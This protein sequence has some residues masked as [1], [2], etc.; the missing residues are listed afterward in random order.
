MWPLT[1][2]DILQD[3]QICSS[4]PI[5]YTPSTRSGSAIRTWAAVVTAAQQVSLAV[6][7]QVLPNGAIPA[8]DGVGAA[9]SGRSWKH[10]R[11]CQL[12]YQ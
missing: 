7:R 4:T 10:A 6:A 3:R 5:V 2:T 12:L 8:Q 11:E 1:F 9:I